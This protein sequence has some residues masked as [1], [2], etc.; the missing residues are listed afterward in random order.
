[1]LILFP[2]FHS[3]KQEKKNERSISSQG[4]NGAEIFDFSFWGEVFI[5]IHLV[6]QLT[7]KGPLISHESRTEVHN[8][9]FLPAYHLKLI[10]G[11][12]S[13]VKKYIIREDDILRSL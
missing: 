2:V 7:A 11:L 10:N 1:M 9:S 13:W 3:L 6:N 8:I 4:A 12:K 5:S